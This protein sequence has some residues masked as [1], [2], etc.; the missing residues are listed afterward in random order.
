MRK[1][2]EDTFFGNNNEDVHDHID[3]VLSIGLIPGMTPAQA[4]TA[5]QTMTDHYQKW[6][7][8]STNKYV[9]SSNSGDGLAALVSKLD[10]LERD[11]K[12]LKESVHI[13]RVK[14]QVCEEDFRMPIILGR[15]L[16]MTAHAKVDVLKKPISL[17]VGNEKFIFKMKSNLPDMQN[18]SVLMIKSNMTTE[19]DE[20][21]N[22]ESDLFT[23]VEET[24]KKKI[25][26]EYWRKQFGVDYD[27]ND[28]FYDLDQCEKDDI[29][30][31]I[32]YLEPT[33]YE[34]FINLDDE[35]YNKRRCRLLGIPYI[36]P[37]PIIIEQ[38]KITQYSLG[39]GEVYTKLEVSNI[40]ELLRTRRNIATIRINIMDEVFKSYEDVT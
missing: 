32:D 22:I 5:I 19:E 24:M 10:N 26:I 13:I 34:R 37:P 1:L 17:E 18:E 12:N 20:L 35:E 36:E 4:L 7:D 8:G 9:K 28:D 29:E 40:E 38:V 16:L 3:R 11:I 27:D 23:E 39:P 2:R 14:C 25:L 15:P 31:I 21:M 33:S 6:H 30:W